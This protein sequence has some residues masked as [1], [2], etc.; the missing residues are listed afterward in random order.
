MKSKGFIVII[1]IITIVLIAGCSAKE[2]TPVSSYENITT[3]KA[4]EMMDNN[5]DIIILDVRTEEEYNE[6]HIQGAI[7]IPDY[8]IVEKV[9][10]TLTDKT[11]TI[12]VY[13][14]TGRRSEL[15][16]NSLTELGYSKVYDFGGIND[17]KY[18]IVTE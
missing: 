14:R 4:K 6:G 11:A 13:C 8:E 7:L 9:Q 1:L 10:D 3:E 15:A 18:E 17:W 12:L 5:T 2:K 16:A